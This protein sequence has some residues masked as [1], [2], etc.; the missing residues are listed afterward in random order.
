MKGSF[1]SISCGALDEN[2]LMDALFGHVP[3]AFSEAH[4][5][6]KGAFLA[7]SGG[8]LLLDEIGNASPKVQQALL[9]ALSVRRIVPLGSDRE[10]AYDARVIAAT[11]VDL[12]QTAISGQGF[13]DDLYYRLAVIT[14]NTPP[15]RRRKEDLP[16]LIR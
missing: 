9:R 5:E 4:G 14:I 1:I 8:T 12:L 15:L 13:R 7:A 3:G 11:N 2:L 16:V 10:I 6:R